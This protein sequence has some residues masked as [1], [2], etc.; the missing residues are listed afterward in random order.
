MRDLPSASEAT[1][2]AIASFQ[3][4]RRSLDDRESCRSGFDTTGP[5][6][7]SS[8]QACNAALSMAMRVSFLVRDRQAMSAS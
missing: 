2:T 3:G 5:G 4:K 7:C 8:A 6:E 1:A